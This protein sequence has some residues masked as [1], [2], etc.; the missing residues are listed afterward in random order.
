MTI[1][2]KNNYTFETA[3]EPLSPYLEVME[4]TKHYLHNLCQCLYYVGVM[5]VLLHI[6]INTKKVTLVF[7]VV[8]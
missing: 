1:L 7:C 4:H 3:E 6:T 2:K 8:G 5:L